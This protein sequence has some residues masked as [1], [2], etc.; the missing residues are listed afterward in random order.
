MDRRATVLPMLAE[1]DFMR[2]LMSGPV[3]EA[4]EGLVLAS[5]ADG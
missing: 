5:V 3:A 2:E 1:I 4:S